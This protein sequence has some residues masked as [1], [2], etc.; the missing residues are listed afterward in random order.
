M[1]NLRSFNNKYKGPNM[2][3]GANTRVLPPGGRVLT[4]LTIG[5]ALFVT[6]FRSASGS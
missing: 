5:I 3:A 6:S 1:N 4:T 2:R